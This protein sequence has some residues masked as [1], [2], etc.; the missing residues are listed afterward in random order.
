ML[1]DELF[2]I[3]LFYLHFQLLIFVT[4][5]LVLSPQC[6]KFLFVVFLHWCFECLKYFYLAFQLFYLFLMLLFFN[7]LLIDCCFL[8][9]NVFLYC[10]F[11]FLHEFLLLALLYF[12]FEVRNLLLQKYILFVQLVQFLWHLLLL[13][14]MGRSFLVLF[15][16]FV[17]F[18][19][20]FELFYLSL[21]ISKLIFQLIE[22][23]LIVQKVLGFLHQ[24]QLFFY[25]LVFLHFIL[26]LFFYFFK[27]LPSRVLLIFFLRL[28]QLVWS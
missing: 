10:L 26:K 27:L 11:G 9:F 6:L 15:G 7:E 25:Q 14:E 1:K 19:S 20:L 18:E 4:Q 17:S 12:S 13:F 23:F 28:L 3:F 8:W 24:L 16:S 22:F 2:F 5:N 21:F